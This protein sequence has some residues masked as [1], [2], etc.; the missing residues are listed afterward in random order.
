MELSEAVPW[1]RLAS[2]YIRMFAL[3]PQDMG[4][5]ILDC[6]G[7]P[8]SFNIEL[9]SQGKQVVSCDPLYQFSREEIAQRIED[10]YLRMMTLNEANKDNFLWDQYGSPAQLG[11]IRMRAMRLFLEDYEAGKQQGRYVVGELPC[12][13]IPANSF[14]MALCSHF[15][16]TYS[17][18]YSA[19][20]HIE[21]MMELARIAAEVRVFPLLTAFSGEISPHLVVVMDALREKR[22]L[23]DVR[24]VEYEFQKGG[25]KML[26]VKR[27]LDTI[28][29]YR[30]K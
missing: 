27:D 24:E 25:N 23:V 30:T 19:E 1:G 13:P 28:T 7:G 2:E 11:Q 26:I 29:A 18:Q 4:G 6:G 17:E 8:S 14:D 20:F 5:R 12:L 16:F 15:L 10:T 9:T 22:Y 3:T 21:S